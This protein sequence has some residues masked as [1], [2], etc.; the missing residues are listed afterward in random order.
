ML[1]ECVGHCLGTV[2]WPASVAVS[3]A[4]LPLD[5]PALAACLRV[6]YACL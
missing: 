1:V 5:M 4:L 3:T 2:H 6:S